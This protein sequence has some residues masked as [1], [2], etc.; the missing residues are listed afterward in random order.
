MNL[1][2]NS[3]G[4]RTLI[5]AGLAAAAG[6]LVACDA[7][8]GGKAA[9]RSIDITGAE[10]AREL[11]LPDADGRPRSLDEF[12]GKVAL[13]FF[14]YTQCPDVCPT[15]LGEIATI[16]K[17]LGA[18]GQRVQPI[19]VTVDPERDTPEILKAYM[20]SFGDDCIA[21]R[22]NEEQIR[23]AAKHFKVFYSKVPGKTAESYT[24]DH[25][26]GTY[27]FDTQG[28]IRLFARHGTPADA[29]GA[30]IRALLGGA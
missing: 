28:R 7:G 30:D 21:L 9:F 14:G 8:K 26:A 6:S 2:A 10:Y 12:K 27:V 25:T 18:D 20:A 22:G 1:P 23:A 3:I 15:T 5:L 4:R 16:R 24:V 19:F 11:K 29:L 17:S 13:V